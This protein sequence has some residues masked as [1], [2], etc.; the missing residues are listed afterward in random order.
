M[1]MQLLLQLAH[2]NSDTMCNRSQSDDWDGYF[3]LP[4]GGYIIIGK[5]LHLKPRVCVKLQ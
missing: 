3:N 4:T 2:S 5:H 1:D